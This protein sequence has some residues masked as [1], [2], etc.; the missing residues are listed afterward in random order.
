[1]LKMAIEY[2]YFQ[3]TKVNNDL[4]PRIVAL[5]GAEYEYENEIIDNP[6]PME[7]SVQVKGRKRYEVVDYHITPYSVIS[8]KIYDILYNMNI[9]GLQFIPATIIGKKDERYE[10]YYFMHIYNY[11]SVMDKD[12]SIYKWDNFIKV[13]NPLQKLILD[14]KLLEEIPLEKRLIFRLKENYMFEL[15][16]KSIVDIIMET[17][18]TGIGF[19]GV[20]GWHTENNFK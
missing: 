5:E 18:P 12:K 19:L 3:L 6:Q 7:Y 20:L 16:H 13:A 8:K 9:E 2:E 11:L 1:M 10:N 15:V 4:H 14:K 17:K